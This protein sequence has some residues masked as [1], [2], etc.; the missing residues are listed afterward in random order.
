VQ[1]AYR[2]HEMIADLMF[3]ARPPALVL[4]E[5][6]LA[7]LA[8]AVVA[9]MREQAREQGTKLVLA[10]GSGPLFTSA[11]STQLAA[12]LKA[13]LKNSMEAVENGGRVEVTVES[14]AFGVQG[15]AEAAV[16]RTEY[17]VPS[18]GNSPAG[19]PPPHFA[20]P[21][22]ALRPPHSVLRIPH[23]RL[24][25]ADTGPGIPPEIRPH[26]FDP[27][28]SGREAGRGLGLGLSKAWRIAELHGGTIEVEG[29]DIGGARLT[30]A[31]PGNGS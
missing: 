17:S 15:S 22:S 31:L 5:V 2:A 21:P 6:D 19:V 9:D 8:K 28:Y 7:K 20:T 1:Q 13:L 25:V 27:Y 23:F 4:E 29:P 10:K 30:I 12:A 3:F 11:D 14:S 18:T 24:A 26:I 16:T